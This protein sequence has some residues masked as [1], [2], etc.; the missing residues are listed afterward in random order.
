MLLTER[1][2]C[3]VEDILKKSVLKNFIKN[4]VLAKNLYRKIIFFHYIFENNKLC[5][6]NSFLHIIHCTTKKKCPGDQPKQNYLMI[7]SKMVM[8]YPN[9]SFR[10][11]KKKKTM[12]IY[13][14]KL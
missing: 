7:G 3:R 8:C 14:K 5:F 6:L 10:S 1:V 4:T 12:S 2:K 13:Q 11:N 9:G